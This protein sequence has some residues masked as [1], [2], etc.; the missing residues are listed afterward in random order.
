MQVKFI[1]GPESE[2]LQLQILFVESKQLEKL[3]L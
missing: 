3:P 1:A 2:L